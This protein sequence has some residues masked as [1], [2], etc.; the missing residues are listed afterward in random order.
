MKKILY[1]IIVVS[2]CFALVG[3]AETNS[4]TSEPPTTPEETTTSETTT[5]STTQAE[6]TLPEITKPVSDEPTPAKDLPR[7]VVTEVSSTELRYYFENDTDDDFVTHSHQ[8]IWVKENDVW[9]R[10]ITKEDIAF[11]S[12]ADAIPARTKIGEG[13]IGFTFYEGIDELP[14]GEYKLDIDIRRH[15]EENPTPRADIYTVSYEF[16]I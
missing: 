12:M 1:S 2:L 8:K 14:K 6:K 7:L 4:T 3:C 9:K 11:G 5:A 13:V 10:L 15:T 16:V